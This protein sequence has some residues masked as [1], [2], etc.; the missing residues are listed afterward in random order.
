MMFHSNIKQQ[1]VY[2]EDGEAKWLNEPN[3]DPSIVV[4]GLNDYMLKM[5]RRMWFGIQKHPNRPTKSDLASYTD[6][7]R[8]EMIFYLSGLILNNGTLTDF[9]TLNTFNKK[10]YWDIFLKYDYFLKVTPIQKP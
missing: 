7:D 4:L 10:T 2:Y 8:Q 9:Q 1:F 3:A 5:I 6:S